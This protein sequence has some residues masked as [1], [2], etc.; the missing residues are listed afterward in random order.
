MFGS[1]S[2]SFQSSPALLLSQM[3]DPTVLTRASAPFM[4]ISPETFSLQI[5]E[6]GLI[7]TIKHAIEHNEVDKFAT[8]PKLVK[9]IIDN[10]D[11]AGITLVDDLLMAIADCYVARQNKQ[12]Y[13]DLF[14]NSISSVPS[15]CRDDVL[16]D[17]IDRFA[18]SAAPE[19]RVLAANSIAIVRRQASV[20]EIFT[21]LA[22]DEDEAVRSEI[23]VSLPDCNFDSETIDAV[24]E[25]ACVDASP[26]VRNAAASVIGTV[27]PHLTEL[28]VSLLQSPETMA[29]ALD[30]FGAMVEY[31]GLA[32]LFLAFAHASQ[33]YPEKCAVVLLE[34]SHNPMVTDDNLLYRCAKLLRHV[35][36]FIT[37]LYEF[38]RCFEWRCGFLR[39]FRIDRM[40]SAEER[41][42][43]AEQA[44][45]FASEFG[46]RLLDVALDFARDEVAEVR[47]ASVKVLVALFLAD[48]STAETISL[49]LHEPTEQRLVLAKV[50]GETHLAPA[51]WDTAKVLSHDPVPAV[52][53][54]LSQGIVG[55]EYCG[56]FFQDFNLP[57]IRELS[58]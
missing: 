41:L 17:F 51:F 49:L 4:P 26:R 38:S 29:T 19:L 5:V 22:V 46:A 14:L 23:V 20:I 11:Q 37:R 21:K 48:Q 40:R 47:D 10:L 34:C 57:V 27:A 52:R 36:A 53:N 13:L 24:L 56:M 25:N 43:Y 28:Y 35:P 39:L 1:S 54:C 2:G 18:S 16:V 12:D 31:A 58:A 3:S 44:A 8:I 9:I 6:T 7:P 45:L 50:I 33:V 55:T 42:L 30:S 15:R 32:P